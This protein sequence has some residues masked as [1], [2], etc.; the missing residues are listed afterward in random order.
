MQRR[1]MEPSAPDVRTIVG[2]KTSSGSTTTVTIRSGLLVATGS[3]TFP[4]YNKSG[5][6]QLDAWGT[7]AIANCKPDNPT[8]HGAV[9]LL[10]LYREGLPHMIGSALWEQKARHA[11]SKGGDEYLNVEF[12]WKPLVQDITDFCTGVINFDSIASQYE[13]DA[14]RVVRRRYEFPTDV[15]EE[16]IKVSN[17]GVNMSPGSTTLYKPFP[18]DAPGPT[19]RHRRTYAKRWFSGAFT[20]HL[21]SDY[22]ARSETS[23]HAYLARHVLGL[24]LT[25]TVLWE[26]A[27]WSW[28][29]DWF[30]NAGDVISNF[31]SFVLDGM[32]M[33]YGYL[34]EHTYVRDTY[35]LDGSTGLQAA[36]IRPQPVIL[37]SES[38][39]RRRATPFGFGLTLSG[40]TLRQK[41]IAAALGL[42][43]FVR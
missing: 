9:A 26:L 6:S 40:L 8:A 39:V 2:S 14:G 29:V 30:T 33:R 31:Q 16:S 28:A 5:D 24:E 20:Y 15:T 38:K 21:P 1:S 43:K 18:D 32:V 25:P 17:S 12:G 35:Y 41:A 27:P 37:M 13:R 23:K 7:K 3:A 11:L 10:E 4:P 22:D 42:T 19:F 34:M 36:S